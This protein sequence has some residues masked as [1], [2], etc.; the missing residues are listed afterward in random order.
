MKFA[1]GNL[2]RETINDAVTPVRPL[3][4]GPDLVKYSEYDLLL[5]LTRKQT[6]VAH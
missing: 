6:I 3:L 4:E 1:Y 2:I 5:Y